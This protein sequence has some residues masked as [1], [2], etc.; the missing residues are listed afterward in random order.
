[1]NGSSPCLGVPALALA[2]GQEITKPDALEEMAVV[3]IT[4]DGRTSL[5]TSAVALMRAGAGTQDGAGAG[6]PLDPTEAQLVL[7]SATL[8][9]PFLMTRP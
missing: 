9:S 5:S 6:A 4:K 7:A 8:L 1:M 2:T 3:S